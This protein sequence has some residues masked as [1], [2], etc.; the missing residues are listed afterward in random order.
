MPEGN[1]LLADQLLGKLPTSTAAFGIFDLGGEG[2]ALLKKSPYSPSTDAQVALEAISE[3]LRAAGTSD[4]IIGLVEKLFNAG[5]KIGLISPEGSYTPEAVIGQ[6]LMFVGPANNQPSPVEAGL[7]ARGV[8]NAN[9]SEK[10][11]VLRT[12]VQE[13]GVKTDPETIAGSEAFS[14]SLPMSQSKIYFAANKTTFG[15]ATSKSALEGLFAS[16]N[17]DTFATIQGLPE[18]KRSVNAL[19]SSDKPISLLFA[20]I[21]RFGPLLEQLGK[22]DEHGEFKPKEIPVEAVALQSSFP[23]EYLHD[24][25]LAITP[26]TETQSTLIRALEASQVSARSMNVPAD[27]AFAIAIDPRFVN[28]INSVQDGVKGSGGEKAFE[29]LKNIRSLSLGLRNNSSGS[30]LP[31]IF[32]SFETADPS[33]LSS[34]IEQSLGAALSMTGQPVKW[35]SKEVLG[36]ST[37]YFTTIIG[38]GAYMTTPKNSSTVLVGT[39]E[40]LIK[41]LVSS[42]TDQTANITTSLSQELRTK[43]GA[44]NAALFYINFARVAE[45]FDSVKNTLAMF[46]G[47]NSELNSLLESTN[48]RAWGVAAG[49]VSSSPGTMSAH[50]G[51]GNSGAPK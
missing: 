45:V 16:A 24:L 9:L 2:Y 50:F 5:K 48:M 13:S 31:D 29:Q 42:Q 46:T 8:S 25:G 44:A 36:N 32:M 33:A 47:G 15:A 21:N 49:S 11:S 10:M 28:T 1:K 17:T 23:K 41:D 43:M 26:R 30:P 14:V 38:A 34:S 22:L 6:A 19:G 4:E 35:Q 37:R 39:S 27:T 18:Y 3:K 12:T 20:S 7:F 40:G 51:I